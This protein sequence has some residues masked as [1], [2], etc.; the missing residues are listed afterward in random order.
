MAARDAKIFQVNVI[1][2][3]L[4]CGDS[5]DFWRERSEDFQHGEAD[6]FFS[7]GE[8]ANYSP[9]ECGFKDFTDAIDLVNELRK[10]H[11]VRHKIYD[12]LVDAQ[13]DSK[14]TVDMWSSAQKKRGE[15]N[16]LMDKAKTQKMRLI[17]AV[18]AGILK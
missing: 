5:E 4:R 9:G 10:T 7:G 17:A 18:E 12:G 8:Y 3:H 15:F 13:L 11:Q 2:I 1:L 6:D 14:Q 16:A